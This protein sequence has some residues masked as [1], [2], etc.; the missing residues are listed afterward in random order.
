MLIYLALIEGEEDKRKF[1]RLYMNYRQTMY[2][3]AYDIL[4]DRAA[5]EDAVHQAFLRVIDHLEKINE[6][7]C[8][9]TRGY[10]VVITKHIAIDMYRARKRAHALSYEELEFSVA[11]TAGADG[12]NEIF[13]AIDL[14]PEKY[15]TVMKLIYIYG[16][17]NGEAARM[18]K[19]TEEAV[20][21]RISRGKKKLSDILNE[22][23]GTE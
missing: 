15:S 2:Y 21:Q 7:D 8:H 13:R 23:D 11:D 12:T 1:E 3:I 22:E 16:Y 9:K 5:S 10:L 14:L 17:T 19:L 4:K 18:L 20:R 6:E